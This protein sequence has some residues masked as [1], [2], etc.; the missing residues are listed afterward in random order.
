ME[1]LI[2]FD[3]TD[4]GRRSTDSTCMDRS[5]SGAASAEPRWYHVPN[6]VELPCSSIDPGST[7]GE[8]LKR[9]NAAVVQSESMKRLDLL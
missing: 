2:L 3:V 6:G 5:G 7:N 8:S 9:D 1:H 4:A